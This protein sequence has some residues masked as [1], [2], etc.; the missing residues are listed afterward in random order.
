[1]RARFVFDVF[2]VYRVPVGESSVRLSHPC[3]TGG[4]EADEFRLPLP[5]PH[6]RADG[7]ML[8]AF[9]QY[10][11]ESVPSPLL[12]PPRQRRGHGNNHVLDLMRPARRHP[13]GGGG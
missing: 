2:S 5:P 1:M 10:R 3:R 6:G 11:R 9:F 8:P 12:F 4:G 13:Q 7:Q